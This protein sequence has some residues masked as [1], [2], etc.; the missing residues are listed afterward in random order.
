LL[1]PL[2]DEWSYSLGAA[3]PEAWLTAYSNL[4][5]EGE[6][7]AGETVLIHAG[8]SGVG[9]AAIQIAREWGALVFVTAGSEDK[10][11]RCRALGATLAIHYK[12]VDFAS[13]VMAFSENPGVDLILDCVGGPY[14]ERHLALLKPYGRL[15]TIGLLGGSTGSL[16]LAAV[17]MKSLTL[18]G[19][20]LR[21]RTP[22][23]KNAFT[24]QFRDRIWPLLAAGRIAPLV[25][26]IFPIASAGEA[27]QY[28]RDNRN[29][30][31]VVLEVRP[32]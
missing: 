22:A 9:T 18:K 23:E 27:H 14:L 5:L 20:R 3:V 7:Q 15:I 12:S 17:L 10:L 16:D 32:A 30:G 8:A 19:T 13:A 31:K 26:R 1:I 11:A 4:C 24:R 29:I 2:P 21:A 25:D 28:V 6:L